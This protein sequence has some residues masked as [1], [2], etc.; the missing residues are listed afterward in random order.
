MA[1]SAWDATR[2]CCVDIP[3]SLPLRSFEDVS[4]AIDTGYLAVNTYLKAVRQLGPSSDISRFNGLMLNSD[5]RRRFLEVYPDG[6]FDGLLAAIDEI[7]TQLD[8]VLQ[9]LYVAAEALAHD[10][11]LAVDVA[12]GGIAMFLRRA[13]NLSDS[14]NEALDARLDQVQKRLRPGFATAADVGT[15]PLAGMRQLTRRVM[16]AVSSTN[17]AQ[18]HCCA[19]DVGPRWRGGRCGVSEF[20][21]LERRVRRCGGR[22]GIAILG[23]D[24][25]L[26]ADELRSWGARL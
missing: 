19:R 7:K 8:E 9:S 22:H 12:A 16:Q 2:A 23:H 5:Y 1:G 6:R 24:R 14:Q 17:L 4:A 26:D 13:A 11:K 20:A 18:C 15:L 25:S 3:A 10:P 21:R